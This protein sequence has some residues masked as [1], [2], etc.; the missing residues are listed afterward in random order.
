MLLEECIW[1]WL[2]VAFDMPKG[3]C[4]SE[5]GMCL[6]SKLELTS[7]IGGLD[8]VGVTRGLDVV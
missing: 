5:F 3:L 7:E 6:Q 1:C 2:A 8:K 4:I